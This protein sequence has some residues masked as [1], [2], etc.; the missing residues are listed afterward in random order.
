MRHLVFRPHGCIAAADWTDSRSVDV[1][2][3]DWSHYS[4]AECLNEGI[5]AFLFGPNAVYYLRKV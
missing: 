3:S 2:A 5:S 1:Q 4:V